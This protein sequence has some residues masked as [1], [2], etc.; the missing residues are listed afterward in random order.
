MAREVQHGLFPER[1]PA[2]G[3]FQAAAR[4]RPARELGGDVHDFYEL[5]PEL[6]GV[7]VGDVSGKG[8]AA[9]LFG[10]FASG[11]ARARAFERLPPAELLERLNRTLVRRGTEGLFCT[12]AFALFDLAGG[13]V[14]IASSGLPYPLR[15][16]AAN[17]RCEPIEIPGLPLGLFPGST[18]DER[19]IDL[20]AGDVFVFHTDGVMEGRRGEEE[21]GPDRF[22]QQICAHAGESADAIA[23]ALLEDVESFVGP[24]SHEDDMSIVVVKAL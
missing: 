9:A 22:R 5:G 20:A 8:V 6:V 1:A 10:A 23:A 7:S 17:G 16:E 24:E 19:T 12:L 3:R 21:Y 18:Y 2:S 14:R 15:F 13:S 4:F 11:T